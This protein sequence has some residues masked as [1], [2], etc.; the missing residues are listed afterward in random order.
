MPELTRFKGIVIKMYFERGS[1]HHKPHIHAQ[2]AEF[3]ATIALDGNLL[4]G[5]L[6]LKQFKIV[7]GWLALYEDEVYEAWH[8]AVQGE[9]FDKLPPF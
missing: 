7:V 8:K 1:K 9:H 4:A 2:Y 6:P 3:K 5:S